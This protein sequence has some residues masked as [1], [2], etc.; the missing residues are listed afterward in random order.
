MI[1]AR[2]RSGKSLGVA[3]LAAYL[4]ACVDYRGVLARG[5]RGIL[6]IMA[7]SKE[8]AGQVFNFLRGIFTQNPRF[9]AMVRKPNGARASGII[10]DRI[11]LR[12]RVDIEVRPSSFRLIRGITAIAAIAEEISTWQSDES[13]NPDYEILA[14]VRPVLATTQ[15]P[16]FAIG[17]PRAKR[18]V[19]WET[20][21]KHF[22]PLGH[23]AILVANGATKTFN[24]TIRQSVIDRAYEDDPAVAASEWG[25]KFRDDLESYVSPETID[26][27]TA[28]GMFQRPFEPRI[29]YVSHC[30]PSGGS[31]DSFVLSIGHI[32]NG[33]G[34]LDALIEHRPPF[35]P[36]MVITDLPRFCTGITLP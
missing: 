1:I 7:G 15:G 8:Q 22:G 36:E 10:S 2:C 26:A 34:I 13:L 9:A 21:R 18:G 14:A 5:E 31:Q 32:E 19:T 3:A 6:P 11:S 30:D 28:R 17:S 24:P 25:G 23:P 16:L 4:A 35:S 20:Y 29:Q 27:C 33:R 12:N